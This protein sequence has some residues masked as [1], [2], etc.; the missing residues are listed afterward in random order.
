MEDDINLQTLVDTIN[1]TEV[2]NLKCYLITRA[3]KEGIKKSSKDK[4]KYLFK[5]YQIN[6][7]DALRSYLY[8]STKD[9]L[10]K[11][12]KKGWNIANYD[13][14]SDD[15]DHLFTYDI[16]GKSFSF[17]D[18]VANQLGR[19]IPRFSKWEEIESDGI[20]LWAY[21]LGFE[22]T[23]NHEWIYTFRKSSS[24]KIVAPK[25]KD[26]IMAMFDTTSFTLSLF[27][28]NAINLDRKIDCVFYKN[29]FYIIRK[30]NFE[31][32]LGLQEEYEQKAIEVADKIAACPVFECG[33]KLQE[34]VKSKPSI[35]KKLI[36]LDKLGGLVDIEKKIVKMKR[37]G[38]R[39]GSEIIVNK[40]KIVLESEKA[41]DNTIKLLCDYYKKGE[42]SGNA[43]GTFSGIVINEK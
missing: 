14:I 24:S 28:G 25:K 8:A 19:E 3:L 23:T 36:K 15:T 6:I 10:E 27:N 16:A 29:V 37:I 4:N 5:V 40:G 35:H 12:N 1:V 20:E 41:I 30:F 18:V 13:V 33:D 2:A 38:K 42:V 39:Y 34:L 22:N 7:D 43:Y 21:C 17:Q 32:I 31:T 11:I 26:I 9:E